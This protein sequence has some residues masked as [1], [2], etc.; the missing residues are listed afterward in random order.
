MADHPI[1]SLLTIKIPKHVDKTNDKKVVTYYEIEI[2]NNYSKATWVLEKRYSDFDSLF[3]TL[4]KL[5][6]KC[7]TIPGKSFLGLSL[8]PEELEKR[9]LQ[10][11]NF[12]QD[13][14]QRQDIMN[15]ESF[16]DFIEVDK[17]S[18][19]SSSNTHIKINEYSE[20]PIGIRD[21][22][23]LKYDKIA[24]V[25]CSEMNV[26]LRIDAY[27]TNVN[28]PW[29]KKTDSHITVGAVFAFKASENS[30][31]GEI[32]FEKLWAKSFP[33]Q[34][35]VIS[36]DSESNTL[37]VG[38]DDGKIYFYKTSPESNYMNY[39]QICEL[40][41]HTDRVMGVAV[42]SKSGYIFSVS[43]D[44]RFVVSESSVSQNITEVCTSTHGY[45]NL[46]HDKKNER[47]FATNEVG[48]ISAFS[49]SSVKFNNFIY[50]TV[51][52]DNTK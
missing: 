32:T 17:H 24:F 38:L 25:A 29:E 41:P 30:Q 1:N 13:C 7:P 6:P 2:Y 50:F 20:L 9:K 52:S 26:A 45:T 19:E 8:S 18:P 35:G 34:T 21:F 49:V 14:A 44:K 51:S 4:N 28:F 15:S 10:L 36:W 27:I 3:K 40:Q 12:M 46:V 22:I 48:V 31:T 37:A 5:F 42:D 43:T 16:R 11:Q 39:E 47:L 23:Y 33:I